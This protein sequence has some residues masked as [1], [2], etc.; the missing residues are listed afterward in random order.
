[1][2]DDNS[3]PAP[4]AGSAIINGGSGSISVVV[5]VFFGSDGLQTYTAIPS[6]G[7]DDSWAIPLF[8][9]RLP[10]GLSTV[11]SV[12]NLSGGV[13]AAGSIQL[14]CTAFAGSAAPP[15]LNSSNPTALNNGQSYSFNPVTD[16]TIPTGWFGA[17]RVAAP[18]N[19]ATI[20]QMRFIGTQNSAA[21]EAISTGGTG[22]TFFT[23]L[24]QKRL[25]NGFATNT[26]VVNLSSSATANVAVTYTPS[27]DYVAAGGSAAVLTF[28]TTIPASS[29]LQ[30][31]HRLSSFAVGATPM[32]DGWYGTLRVVSSNQPIAGFTQI[33]NV[34]NLPGDTFMTYTA[35]TRP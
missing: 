30:Q 9:S 15:A 33:T 19:T 12:Q 20:I 14:N 11:V 1:V 26:T 34:N 2:A 28:N 6:T 3:V 16:M 4:F 18:G 32:P 8:N 7:L 22:K 24:V 35:F 5:N 27:P 13:A 17:C 10:N 21:Y 31:N 23:P 25:G 29:S